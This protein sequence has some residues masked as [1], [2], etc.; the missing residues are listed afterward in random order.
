MNNT[1]LANGIKHIE[2][3]PI[4]EF[5]G[6]LANLADYEITE[7]V[8]GAQLLCGIDSHGFYTSRESKGGTRRYHAD[9]YGLKFS[10]TYM[11][12]AHIALESVIDVLR[13]A[14]L[15]EGSQIEVEVLYG[16]IPNVVQYSADTNYL[17]FL[18]T[19]SGT[20]DINYLASALADYKTTVSARLPY[21]SDGRTIEF[22]ERS[23]CWTFARS[24]IIKLNTASLTDLLR[25]DI[26]GMSCYL[27]DDSGIQGLTNRSIEQTPLNKTPGWCRTSDWH[28]VKELVRTKRSE[29]KNTLRTRYIDRI[30][31][32]LLAQI[33]SPTSSQF[34]PDGGWIEGVVLKHKYTGHTA[35]LVD[36]DVFLKIK[37]AC[38]ATRN[39][40]AEP[41]K[42]AE[43]ACSIMALTTLKLATAIGHP[44]LG[45]MQSKNYLRTIG[46]STQERVSILAQTI[47]IP[48]VKYMLS[49]ILEESMG[50]LTNKLH[51]Y[52][53]E[54]VA[55]SSGRSDV[56]YNTVYSPTIIRRTKEAFAEA[57]AQIENWHNF[58]EE[59]ESSAGGIVHMIA[60]KKL[61]E[62]S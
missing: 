12:T 37:D 3:L 55:N 16:E 14:G 62:I 10:E 45:T 7:K 2:D 6:L 59:N 57:F 23:G 35:K 21:T 52:E 24:S 61:I 53:K 50:E 4:S 58:L 39:Q 25:G 54:I 33:V 8:D 56:Q 19:V 43:L 13:T 38:W 60:G 1:E 32:T 31:A 42:T 44:L 51:E 47:D 20:A 26:S 5:M 28:V 22:G 11:R 30:K 34:G 41:A 15:T 48:K 29:I 36:K 46:K 40:L 17:I 49:S 18:R 27:N 9:D